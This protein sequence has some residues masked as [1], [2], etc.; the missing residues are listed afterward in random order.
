M[1][2]VSGNYWL[3]DITEIDDIVFPKVK[4]S[5][6]FRYVARS[7]KTWKPSM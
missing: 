7:A 2:N 4:H 1:F 6:G 5:L 3:N